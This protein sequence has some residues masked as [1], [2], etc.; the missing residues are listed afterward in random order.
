MGG[1]VSKLF[2][3]NENFGHGI[4]GISMLKIIIY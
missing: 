1:P 3:I 4:G 2:E